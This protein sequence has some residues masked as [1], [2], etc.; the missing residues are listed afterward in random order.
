MGVFTGADLTC[1]AGDFVA[2]LAAGLAVSGA[3][4]AGC[5]TTGPLSV[6]GVRIAPALENPPCEVTSG[7]TAIALVG[8]FGW[9]REETPQPPP[10]T[11][12][13]I[14]AAAAARARFCIQVF[15]SRS[16]SGQRKIRALGDTVR[17]PT[18]TRSSSPSGG[19]SRATIR[20]VSSNSPGPEVLISD[21]CL[22][23]KL[24]VC[25]SNPAIRLRARNS[26]DRTLDSLMPSTDAISTLVSSSKAESISTWRSLAGNCST[27]PSTWV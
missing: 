8:W 5:A 21:L 10:T 7:G 15:S 11:T 16:A 25:S 14:A 17:N 2:C 23:L 27:Q 12:A 24:L 13:T 4:V 26:L 19:E 1:R 6:C 18:C 9:K 3:T 20:S 22:H